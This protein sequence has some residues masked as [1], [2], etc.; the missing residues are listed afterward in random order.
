MNQEFLDL[1]QAKLK[2][3]ARLHY[4]SDW[5]P[6]AIEVQELLTNNAWLENQEP[7]NGFAARPAWRPV[8]KFER[9]G[10]RLEHGTYDLIM[11]KT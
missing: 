4:A 2:T 8:T 7:D 1:I 11:I 9:R 6:Y 10:Q 5:E 3:G